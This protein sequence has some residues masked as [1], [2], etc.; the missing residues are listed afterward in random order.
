MASNILKCANCN[1]VI[2]ELLAFL[3]NVL[4]S[5]DEE[6]LHQLCTETF[7]AEEIV[8]AKKL[9]HE[10][11]PN[12]KKMP[13][14]RRG[15]KKKLSRDLDDIICLM[16]GTRSTD[17]FPVFVAKDLHKL[18]PVTFEHIDVTRL[19]RE[20]LSV[21]RHITDL[22]KRSVNTESF[23]LL[24]EEVRDMKQASIQYNKHP[25]GDCSTNMRIN[26][27]RGACASLE[28]SF[29]LDSGPMGLEYVPT[30]PTISTA[31]RIN[32]GLT[33]GIHS[34]CLKN[35]C[36]SLLSEQAN[37]TDNTSTVS[38][39]G[40]SKSSEKVRK[41]E[42][43]EGESVS[44]MARSCYDA[45]T[46]TLEHV[47]ENETSLCSNNASESG[48]AVL[49]EVPVSSVPVSIHSD[50]L[51]DPERGVRASKL[52]SNEWQTVTRKTP[53]QYRL[54]SQKGC[55]STTP[56]GKFR[57]AENKVPLFISN[58]STETLECDIVNYI[59]EKTNDIVSLKKINMKHA[60]NYNAYKLYVSKHKVDIYLNDQFWPSGVS[61][62]RFVHFMY[63]TNTKNSL[64][65]ND[66]SA[67]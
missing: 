39:Q 32:G 61:F 47:S 8:I 17:L 50:Q 35:D 1:V 3:Q 58:V 51:N 42:C 18:P 28:D 64:K 53:K 52:F 15:G 13:L 30:N 21:K 2:N 19:M 9:L 38:T 11:L 49:R 31:D 48:T 6:S 66:A 44:E 63:R 41:S 62:R 4:D 60:R 12:S 10:S 24:K 57:A 25:Q 59:K 43:T 65:L 5:M 14:R 23:E 16:K 33:A 26:K 29:S 67:L 27:K 7:S 55:A 40:M 56:R 34:T 45:H 22:E 20:I 54:T 46:S 36:V 37:E